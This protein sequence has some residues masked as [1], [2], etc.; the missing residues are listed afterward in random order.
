M[1][2]NSAHIEEEGYRYILEE[3][4]H[5]SRVFSSVELQY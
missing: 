5:L 2:D 3:Y 4:K 1:N